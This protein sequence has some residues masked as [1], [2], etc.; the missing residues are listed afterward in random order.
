MKNFDE[1]LAERDSLEARTFQLHGQEFVRRVAIRPERL[2]D[3]HPRIAA[4][5]GGAE[6]F[7]VIDEYM[8]L[9]I[10]DADGAHDRYRE[11]RADDDNAV[12]SRTLFTVVGWLFQEFT[13]VPT[14][15][16]S[17]SGNGREPTGSGSTG[18]SSSTAGVG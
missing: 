11:L 13:S 2:F 14:S 10:E 4:S 5:Q 7:A 15:A 1:E 17:T 16:P 8:L 18:K 9:M 12:T 6:T 3:Y